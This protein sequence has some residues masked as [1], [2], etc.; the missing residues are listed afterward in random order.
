MLKVIKLILGMKSIFR[1]TNANRLDEYPFQEINKLS[2]AQVEYSIPKHKCTKWILL[3]GKIYADDHYS[4][5]VLIEARDLI[6]WISHH[7]ANTSTSVLA[8]QQAKQFMP[9]WLE[10]AD[11]KDEA[12]TILDKQ[13][14]S[15]IHN[16]ISNFKKE[17]T[18]RFYCSDCKKIY[19]LVKEIEHERNTE[20]KWR[21]WTNEWHC[22]NGHRLYYKE[23]RMHFLV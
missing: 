7:A 8:N 11:M 23:S 2:L 1:R 15:V 18:A 21:S 9:T 3:A 13:M 19:S 12:V 20:G 6:S 10:M 4:C 22:E 14:K 16:Y 17:G 5:A